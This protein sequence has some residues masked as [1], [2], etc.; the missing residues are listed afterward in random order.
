MEDKVTIQEMANNYAELLPQ[1]RI[2]KK[3]CQID[4]TAG[5]K[6]V[7]EEIE[8]VVNANS[9]LGHPF[10]TLSMRLGAIVDKIRELKGE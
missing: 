4:Y 10:P 8:K 6:A 3:F 2:A 7:L 1:K 5:A 9:I